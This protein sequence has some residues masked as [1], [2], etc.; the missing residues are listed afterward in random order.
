MEGEHHG[1]F[2]DMSDV[3]V[4]QHDGRSRGPNPVLFRPAPQVSDQGSAAPPEPDFENGKYMG[5]NNS[6]IDTKVNGK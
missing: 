6:G 4:L 5:D 3:S 1:Q 2:V